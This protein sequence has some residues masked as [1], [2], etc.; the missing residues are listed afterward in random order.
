M[1]A[2][3][4]VL[5]GG[6]ATLVSGL[7][8]L[9]AA[10]VALLLALS[11]GAFGPYP[12]LLLVL[13]TGTA[14]LIVLAAWAPRL[15]GRARLSGAALAAAAV[16]ATLGCLKLAALVHP[17]KPLIDAVFQA[18]RLEWVLAGRYFFT[19]PLPDG[20]AFPYA[21]GL[22]VTAAPLAALVTDHVLLLRIVTI[23]AEAIAG[24]VL[25]ALVARGFSDRAAGVFAVVLFHVVPLPYT[26]IGNANLTN[27]FAQAVALMALGT[28]ALLPA[29]TRMPRSA[30]AWTGF[31]LLVALAFL[32]HVSTIVLL[33][34]ILGVTVVAFVMLGRAE[35]R[36]H[37]AGVA[38]AALLAGALAVG[39]YYRHF[40]DVYREFVARVAAPASKAEPAVPAATTVEDSGGAPAV[41][42]RPLTWTERAGDAARQT[43]ANVGWPI[44]TLAAIGAAT[45]LRRFRDP[46]TLLVVSWGVAWLVFLVGGT[47]TR[48]DT[49]YQRYAAEF[50]SR[51]NLASYP[52][53]V[54]LAALGAS[55]LWRAGGVVRIVAAA[56]LVVAAGALGASYWISWIR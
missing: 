3:A 33:A 29:P 28:L 4:V 56:L 9:A 37:A 15:A 2:L 13:S 6:P 52:A 48:V 21:I 22:Y 38:I 34:G 36:R 46:A 19:Q 45:R 55:G 50:I 30:A 47:L 40:D 1:L 41:L 44:L 42:V 12:T 14:A 35:L 16:S 11:A 53:A 5:A 25:Y 24:V 26:V 10:G 51:V 27:A 31:T 54:V 23:A 8:T 17:A 32:S 18:H 49:Q 7:T 43:G 39:L 20:V